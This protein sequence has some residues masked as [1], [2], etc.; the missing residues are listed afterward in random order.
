MRFY[1]GV[2]TA[3]LARVEFRDV[4]MFVSHRALRDRRTV[5]PPAVGPYAVDSGGFTE[6]HDEGRW[7]TTAAD[8]LDSLRRYREQI[9]PFDFAACQ[10]WMCD[11][12]A[13]AATGLTVHEHQ[14]RTIDSLLALRSADP[15]L[16]IA[17]VLQ[18]WTYG[19]FIEHTRMWHDADVD[20]VAEPVVM[21]GSI[22]A[23]EGTAIA[24]AVL[25]SM[26]HRGIAV[27]ALGVKTA[28]LRRAAHYLAS[29]DSMAWS[30]AA[31]RRVMDGNGPMFDDCPHKA[32][33]HCPRW[34]LLWREQVMAGLDTPPQLSIAYV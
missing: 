31:R 10:D 25:A 20:L 5:F 7:V 14:Q 16:P 33:S 1:L 32:C 23:R 12:A 8:Y 15:S 22:A 19:D 18:G 3:W 6:V 27:H 26:Y 24:E 9:G 4:P 2:E 13:L 30:F 34:A 11:P 28:G 17:P 29:A 21:V